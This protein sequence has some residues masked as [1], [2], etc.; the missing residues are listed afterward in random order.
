[1]H[2]MHLL[3]L[4]GG[5]RRPKGYPTLYIAKWFLPGFMALVKNCILARKQ[6]WKETFGTD[7][8]GRPFV[9]ELINDEVFIDLLFS[10]STVERRKDLCGLSQSFSL[11]IASKGSGHRPSK[12]FF[13]GKSSS[14]K[15][16]SGPRPSP[17]SLPSPQTPSSSYLCVESLVPILR[18]L[19]QYYYL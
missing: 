4:D 19:K 15:R 13:R 5:T 14:Y 12:R 2:K 9:K 3:L 18:V 7:A 16:S 10:P 1:M 8:R 11:I 17:Y 6:L